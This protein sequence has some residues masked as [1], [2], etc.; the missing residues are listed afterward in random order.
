MFGNC[1]NCGVQQLIFNPVQMENVSFMEWQREKTCDPP[2]QLPTN[3]LIK[4]EPGTT[5]SERKKAPS[6][7][8]KRNRNAESLEMFKN[9]F[10]GETRKFLAHK[11]KISH[12]ARMIRKQKSSLL[13]NQC[14]IVC[15]WSQNAHGKYHSQ[16]Q[17]MHW[18][19]SQPQ[20]SLH[21][22]VIYRANK[23]LKSFC[24]VSDCPRH[25]AAAIYAHLEPV[26]EMITSE[27]ESIDEV[28]FCTDGPTAQYRSAK[29][30]DL[31]LKTAPK[32]GFT[33][34][35]WIFS[36]AGH[37]KSPADAV[38]GTVKRTA[39][40]KVV[41]GSDILKAADFL[42]S[43]TVIWKCEIK[44]EDVARMDDLIQ[45][46]LLPLPNTMA[47]KQVLIDF[48]TEKIQ[49]RTLACC[50][51]EITVHCDHFNAELPAIS[52]DFFRRVPKSRKPKEPVQHF[53]V[54][55]LAQVNIGDVKLENKEKAARPRKVQ[56]VKSN[57]T[58]KKKSQKK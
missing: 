37:G 40:E 1:N 7:I 50:D 42:W 4:A 23:P 38:G 18:G 19:Q 54:A 5:V 20:I 30:F 49:L 33:K 25:D 32:F 39:D 47:L 52:F 12:Q 3:T 13:P 24:T 53:N 56:I 51:C 10:A 57:S 35:Q 14:L 36:E 45:K 55:H 48:S 9:N 17:S 27:D 22:G 11:L 31:L 28:I 26:L 58:Q 6:Y 41:Q 8:T 15:D 34:V 2:V 21:T 16:V 29:N 44:P 46:P 43:D